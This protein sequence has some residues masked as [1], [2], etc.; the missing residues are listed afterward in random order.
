MPATRRA[1]LKALTIL[2]KNFDKEL[3]ED[4]LSIYEMVLSDLTEPQINRMLTSALHNQ[5]AFMPRPG[6]LLCMAIRGHASPQTEAEREWVRLEDAITTGKTLGLRP[7]TRRVA[8]CFGTF[9]RL[10]AMPQRDFDFLRQRFVQLYVDDC[11]QTDGR[12]HEPPQIKKTAEP[13]QVPFVR[14]VMKRSV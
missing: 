10:A 1:L 11:A 5:S 6:Q 4:L 13:A 12:E 2:S 8:R 7:R 9:S 14:P 3:D